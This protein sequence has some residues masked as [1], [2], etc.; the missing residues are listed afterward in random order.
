MKPHI[1]VKEVTR[2]GFLTPAA[3][4]QLSF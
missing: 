4:G 2:P 1:E 3:T